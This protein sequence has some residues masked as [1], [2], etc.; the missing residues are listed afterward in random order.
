MLLLSIKGLPFHYL[1]LI[2]FLRQELLLCQISG[3]THF[4]VL[5]THPVTSKSHYYYPRLRRHPS[6]SPSTRFFVP[7]SV[8]DWGPLLPVGVPHSQIPPCFLRYEYSRRKELVDDTLPG[9]RSGIL[10]SAD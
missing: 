7:R 10:T 2:L 6:K 5:L 4:V 1:A 3:P 8:S 9:T